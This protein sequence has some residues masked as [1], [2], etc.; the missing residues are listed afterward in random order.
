MLPPPPQILIL[1]IFC[2][3]SFC[4]GMSNE[5]TGVIVICIHFC[6]LFYAIFIKKIKLPFWYYAGAFCFLLG[7]LALY[8]SPGHAKRAALF[9]KLKIE[10]YSIGDILHMSLY[11]KFERINQ[12]M[13]S[14]ST[15]LVSFAVLLLCFICDRFRQKRW[16]N[17]AIIFGLGILYAVIFR[18]PALNFIHHLIGAFLFIAILYYISLVYKNEN[19]MDL[20]K[21]Y[22]YSFIL[23]IVCHIS[24]LLTLQVNI[25]PRA[26]LFVVLIGI[27]GL[28]LACRIIQ[29]LFS[30]AHNKIQYG[31][32]ACCF[33]YGC[34]VLSAYVDTH[35]KWNKMSKYIEEQKSQGVED[36]VINSKYFHSFYKRYGDW[37]NPGDDP[38][39]FP[40]PDYAKH[41]GV[42]TFRV[43][44]IENT[45]SKAKN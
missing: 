20:S 38:E 36:I 23:F 27:I 14:T 29:H 42:R 25:P 39:V 3:A 37:Q 44:E 32:L 45:K 7:F 41:F 22:Y 18:I 9:V 12:V 28:L 30:Q 40:N 15:T 19:N 21:L 8:L 5:V 1:L 26:R 2:I 10:Y 34:F 35:M 17:I 31:I 16:G 11:E 33:V 13:K 24:L 4:A 43:Q 6:L